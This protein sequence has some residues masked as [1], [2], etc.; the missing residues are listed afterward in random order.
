MRILALVTDAVEG[1]GGIAQTNRDVLEALTKSAVVDEI[2]VLPRHLMKPMSES[3]PKIKEKSPQGSKIKYVLSALFCLKNEGRFD[4]I[5]CG[6][7]FMTPIA[8]VLAWIA[9]L[10]MWV[11][12]YGI[13][14]WKKKS[15]LIQRSVERA[16]LVTAISRYT[17]REFMSWVNCDPECVRIL[18]VVVRPEFKIGP[19]PDHLM[20][21]YQLEQKKVLLTVGRYSSRE[22]YK[23]H[24]RVISVLPD[25]VK[26]YPDLVY[27][28]AGEGDDRP[29]LED[30]AKRLGVDGVVKFIGRVDE[31]EL[32]DVY[33]MADV[34]VMPSTGE[35]FGIV[36]L[37]AARCGIPVVGGNGDGSFDALLEGN[38]GMAVDVHKP[39]E[40]AR[41]IRE[42]LRVPMINADRANIFCK[43]TMTD[44]IEDLVKHRIPQA[45]PDLISR[46]KMSFTNSA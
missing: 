45:T 41:A 32:A 1:Y 35:G 7:I 44:F 16:A 17:R 25:L 43:E 23:G 40:I 18:P 13:E 11:H 28:I 6:H 2:V 4:L 39:E 12:I 34:F 8:A 9:G 24:D 20:R 21:R 19:K 46:I 36:F 29:R 22:R 30:L 5:Y 42:N 15:Q 38:I 3:N 10:P 31:N 27:V 33:R 37:E 14:A 26:E